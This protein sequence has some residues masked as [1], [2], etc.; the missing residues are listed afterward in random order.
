MQTLVCSTQ[1]LEGGE[2]S[3]TWQ[4]RQCPLGRM[5]C[6]GVQSGEMDVAIAGTLSPLNHTNPTELTSSFPF[7]RS[8]AQGSNKLGDIVTDPSS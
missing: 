6:Q 4:A 3:K 1:L 5:Q 7:Y 2:V 8:N